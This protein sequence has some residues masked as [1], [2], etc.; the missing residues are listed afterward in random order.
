ME[1]QLIIKTARI[2]Y[3]ALAHEV[4]LNTTI[5]SGTGLGK[6]FAPTWDMVNAS[7]S[8]LI[9]WDEYTQQYR[10]LMRKRYVQQRKSFNAVI[11]L[12]EIVLLCYCNK[13]ECH[14]Y[15]LADILKQVAEHQG[16]RVIE[17]GECLNNRR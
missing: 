16:I 2:G 7:K 11:H 10:N 14:R 9:S 15:L 1:M 4:L 5:G 6:V 3:K 17:A 13:S 8:G 12:Q